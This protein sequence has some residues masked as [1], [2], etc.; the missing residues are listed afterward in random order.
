MNVIKKAVAVI[1]F[2]VWILVFLHVAS[3]CTTER[4]TVGT[5]ELAMAGGTEVGR[6]KQLDSEL[7][8]IS[9]QARA[10]LARAG[11]SSLELGSII[12]RVFDIAFGLCDEIDNL[13]GE[14]AGSAEVEPV[15]LDGAGDNVGAEN[16]EDNPRLREAGN[17]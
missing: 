1:L 14:I 10:E 6:L 7:A 12:S 11:N 9:E 15:A 17:Q 5:S 4:N 3:G 13:R 2:F 16:S 8:R